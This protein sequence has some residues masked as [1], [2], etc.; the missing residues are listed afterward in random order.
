MHTGVTNYGKYRD[1]TQERMCSGQH[2]AGGES[3][4]TTKATGATG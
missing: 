4:P 1:L 2:E 3:S